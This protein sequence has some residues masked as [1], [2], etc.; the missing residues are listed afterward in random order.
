MRQEC[1][2]S[3]FC[4]FSEET[5]KGF[6]GLYFSISAMTTL[7]LYSG[8][9][10][11]LHYDTI[12]FKSASANVS[13]YTSNSMY[14]MFYIKMVCYLSQLKLDNVQQVSYSVFLWYQILF[15]RHATDSVIIQWADPVHMYSLVN[16]NAA[17]IIFLYSN[18]LS[19]VDVLYSLVCD[20]TLSFSSANEIVRPVFGDVCQFWVEYH[21]RWAR[22]Q[23]RWALI[24]WTYPVRQKRVGVEK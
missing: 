21:F 17:G 10:C 24:P 14:I 2:N 15:S 1:H 23:I 12:P 19:S 18:V 6:E 7:L 5:F 3:K 4:D 22:F 11:N 16:H 8:E 9:F 13:F 20:K